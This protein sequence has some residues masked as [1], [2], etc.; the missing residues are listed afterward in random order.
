MKGTFTF[1]FSI[2]LCLVNFA[3]TGCVKEG[4]QATKIL[5]KSIQAHGGKSLW[6]SVKVVSYR[7]ETTLY[8]ASGEIEQQIAQKITHKFR[9]QIT[10]MLWMKNGKINR[11]IKNAKE[12]ILYQ[13]NQLQK[14]S[15][16]IAKTNSSLDA[17]LY[18]F[19]Q[20][21]KLL[22]K[23]VNLDYIGEKKLLDS[24]SVYGIRVTY[25]NADAGDTWI[26]YFDKNNYRLRAAQVNHNQRW[27]LIVNESVEKETGLFL[28][29]KRKSY[30]LDSLG[31][32]K[33]LRAAYTYR[34]QSF[35]TD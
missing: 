24:L 28:N 20:P 15:L 7:K 26:Y 21:Y 18:V 11:A 3:I 29:K 32:I 22:D 9:P 27:S 2:L 35:D 17:A 16:L 6:E 12:V 25:S 23:K 10:E 31:K 19:W 34:I 4:S 1:I 14:D 8:S 5:E 33:S 30:F 13:N